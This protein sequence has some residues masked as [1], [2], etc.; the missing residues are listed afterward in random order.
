MVCHNRLDLTKRTLESYVDT[1]KIPHRL[2]LVNNGS[3]DGHTDAT[4]RSFA[5]AAKK[6]LPF[7]VE[8][9]TRNNED[10]LAGAL[11]FAWREYDP[12]A[13]EAIVGVVGNDAIFQDGWLE[14]MLDTMLHNQ[15]IVAL[16]SRIREGERIIPDVYAPSEI[17]G[18]EAL[19]SPAILI[20]S[21]AIA[22][23]KWPKENPREAL[24]AFIAG[25]R[26]VG[27][28]AYLRDVITEHIG[29]GRSVNV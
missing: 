5:Q 6:S 12:Y 3:N 20:R 21:R 29:A 10:R 24:F 8:V 28:L 11:D 17:I 9:I 4:L 18:A 1:V 26:D 2:I 13:L 14:A 7:H 15:R 23:R 25:L 22:G 16:A 19:G 27:R